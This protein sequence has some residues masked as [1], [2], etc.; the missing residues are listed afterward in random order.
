[1]EALTIILHLNGKEKEFSTPNFITGALF[2]TAAEI[3]EDL[4]SN[5][6]ERIYTSRQSEFICEVFGNKFTAE[7]F[8]Q[9][10]DSRLL[11]R[12]I[13]ATANYVIGNIVEASKILNPETAEEAEPGE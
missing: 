3:T 12:T 5:D 8:E 11:Y 7:E 1:M 4:E 2:R 6:P 9:G 10:I 13:Y